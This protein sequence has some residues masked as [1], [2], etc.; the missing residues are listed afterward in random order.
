M[1]EVLLLVFAFLVAPAILGH[2]SHLQTQPHKFIWYQ[3]R[4]IR[5]RRWEKRQ[6]AMWVFIASMAVLYAAAFW[7][8]GGMPIEL[9]TFIIIAAVTL[10]TAT[11][12]LYCY[13]EK[14]IAFLKP[15]LPW[16]ALFGLLAIGI[17]AVS[18]ILSDQMIAELT[19]LPARDLPGA[20]LALTLVITPMVWFSAFAMV[21]G[22]AAAGLTIVLQ[23]YAMVRDYLSMRKK[24]K[25]DSL[26]DWVAVCALFI[27]GLLALT[28]AIKLADKQ[29]YAGPVREAI[30]FGAFH[31]P[32]SYCGLPGFRGAKVAVLHDEVGAIALPDEGEGY[33]FEQVVCVPVVKGVEELRGVGGPG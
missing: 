32:P 13:F 18:K 31:L 28:L 17:A 29:T 21:L 33:R 30:V 15:L 3:R 24:R 27:G 14:L 5:I 8:R 19:G 26:Y 11:A 20:Q 25:H 7:K 22:L 1:F 2:L 6:Y 9:R 23:L 12:Y 16:K 10:V 4:Y